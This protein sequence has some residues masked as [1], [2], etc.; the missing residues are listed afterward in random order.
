MSDEAAAQEPREYIE[1]QQV[2]KLANMAHTGGQAK[3]MIQGGEVKVNG[4]VETR[5]RRKLYPGDVVEVAG[6]EFHLAAE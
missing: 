5:R 2:L 6:E 4:E 1:L 3:I